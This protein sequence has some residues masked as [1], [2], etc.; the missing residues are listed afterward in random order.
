MMTT[1]E[2]IMPFDL[3][4]LA[5]TGVLDELVNKAV[6]NAARAARAQGL[7][8]TNTEPGKFAVAPGQV[9]VGDK[10]EHKPLHVAHSR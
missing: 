10:A 7:P 5:R 1:L 8:L 3:E 9:L 4:K 6:L 2:M